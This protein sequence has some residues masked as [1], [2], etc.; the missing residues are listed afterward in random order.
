MRLWKYSARDAVP[1]GVTMTQLLLSFYIAVH[2]SELSG[3]QAAVLWIP[4]VL[5]FW[6]NPIISTH[7]FIHTPFFRSQGLNHLYAAL[8]SINLGFPQILYRFQHFNH[9]RF[10]NDRK[11]E[12]GKTQDHSSSFAR[13]TGGGYENVLPYSLFGVFRNGSNQAI[14]EA[15][16]SRQRGQLLLE[17][18]VC[19][20]GLLALAVISWHFFLAFYLT[21]FLFGWALANMENYYEHFGAAPD[22]KEANSISYYGKI[23]NRLFCNEGYHQEHHLRPQA[24][25]SERPRV[26]EELKERLMHPRRVVSSFPPLLGFLDKRTGARL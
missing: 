5:L 15:W 24:H 4:S 1:F 20:A 13:G 3:W 9:H 8:N 22:I 14:R 6:Y 7:N 11:N 16:G 17:L 12:T 26:L 23:Y 25:Y 19:V 18:A 21:S 10:E 2:W